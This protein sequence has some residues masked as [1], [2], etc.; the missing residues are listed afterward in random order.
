MLLSGCET[1]LTLD[2]SPQALLTIDPSRTSTPPTSKA[3]PNA[4]SSPASGSG[5]TPFGAPDGLTIDL[6]GPVPVLANLSA[7]QAKALGLMTSGTCG[8]PG[9]T[10]SASA[11]LQ[12]SLENRLRAVTQALGST[13][14][15]L[16]WKAWA[17]PSGL[18]RSRL[19]ASAL[20]T[21][22]IDCS[23]WPTP[24]AR[25]HFPA[26][27]AEYIA[28]KKALGHGMANLN[29]LV[30]LAGWNTPT[31]AVIDHK[32]KPPIIG[33]RKPTDPQISLAD[34]AYHLASWQTPT[35]IDSRRGEYQYDQGDKS[36]PRLSNLG[37]ARMAGPARLTASGVLLTGSCAGMESGGQLAP[38]HSRWLMGLP[39]AWDEC[40]PKSLPKSRKK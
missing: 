11:A 10:S 13:L 33:N 14:F 28:E 6:F 20:R 7:R 3:S 30:Q 19:R 39:R 2:T 16:T 34:Q 8:R 15:K 35:S 5:P 9:F 17:T 25:D 32:S 38:S 29:D 18:S 40:A 26:H 22:G 23:G 31:T 21:S 37:M 1:S 24:T 4:T 12:S 27:S 36:R